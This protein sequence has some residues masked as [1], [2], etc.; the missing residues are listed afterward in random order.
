MDSEILKNDQPYTELTSFSW[1]NVDKSAAPAPGASKEVVIGRGFTATTLK[2]VRGRG[3]KWRVIS[4]FY[5][6]FSINVDGVVANQSRPDGP[7]S[8]EGYVTTEDY[9]NRHQSGG[10][11]EEAEEPAN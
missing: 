10:P 1:T 4:R 8:L 9:E 2:P 11:P 6:H 7:W 5:G 3:V